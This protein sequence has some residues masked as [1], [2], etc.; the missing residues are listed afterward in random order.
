MHNGS[1]SHNLFWCI[2]GDRQEYAEK[3]PRTQT[4]CCR[5]AETPPSSALRLEDSL[6]IG[7]HSTEHSPCKQHWFR[8]RKEN[9]IC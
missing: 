4:K 7:Q 1:T 5:L 3:K 6:C 8:Q 2:P 9:K